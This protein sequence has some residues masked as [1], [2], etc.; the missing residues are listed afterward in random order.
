M[1]CQEAKNLYKAYSD[2]CCDTEHDP[3][4]ED[5]FFRELFTVMSNLLSKQLFSTNQL[6][7]LAFHIGHDR[8]EQHCGIITARPEET[9]AIGFLWQ[10]A[11]DEKHIKSFY[12]IVL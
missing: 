12:P 3:I 7:Q 9:G 1:N 5:Q 8:D 4:P 2:M 10:F 6:L 11:S